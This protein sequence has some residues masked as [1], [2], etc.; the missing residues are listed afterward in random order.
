MRAFRALDGYAMA[1]ADFFLDKRS[2]AV[3]F[4]EVNTIPGFTP[5]SMYPLLWQASG[6]STAD[7]LDRLIRLALRRR[8]ARST[9]KTT[10]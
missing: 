2:G 4:N 5:S 6:V 3:Y 8:R 1:R 9:L 7:L 10:P